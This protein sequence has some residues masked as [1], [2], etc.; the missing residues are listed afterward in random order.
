M[1]PL[2]QYQLNQTRRQFFGTSGL[3]LGGLAL[4]VLAKPLAA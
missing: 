3:R 4:A 2:H 1:H